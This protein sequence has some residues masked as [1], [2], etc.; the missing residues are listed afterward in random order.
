M[1]K[2]IEAFL[3]FPTTIVLAYLLISKL[4]INRENTSD[5]VEGII[6][7]YAGNAKSNV[8]NGKAIESVIPII[9]A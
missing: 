1:I 2:A 7:M 6:D 8:P 5:V 3:S 4:S 9:S